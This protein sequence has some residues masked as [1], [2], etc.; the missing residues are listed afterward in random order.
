MTD[1][2]YRIVTE[3]EWRAL[4]RSG[5]FAGAAHDLKDGYI[6]LSAPRQVEGTLAAHYPGKPGLVLLS[7]DRDVLE[8][9]GGKLVWEP[10]RGGEL[11][12][13]FYGLIPLSAVVAHAALL[14]DQGG[15][16][17]LPELD[18]L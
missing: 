3:D 6:H 8:A 14:L 10:S 2:L 12:P 7:I 11:F 1:L 15:K 18:P 9:S 17:V 5:S 13:H 16:H 4:A